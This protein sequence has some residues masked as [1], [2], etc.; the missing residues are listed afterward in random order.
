MMSKQVGEPMVE[1]Q[2][3]YIFKEESSLPT[4][5]TYAVFISWAMDAMEGLK[6]VMEGRKVV[7]CNTPGVFLQA[8][9]PKVNDCYLKFESLMVKM[10]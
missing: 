3:K 6:V 1:P 2:T 4:L 5:S 9:W 8:N 10:I 7:T